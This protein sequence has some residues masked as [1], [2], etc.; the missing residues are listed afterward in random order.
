MLSV[1]VLAFS[2]VVLCAPSAA[3]I[4]AAAAGDCSLVGQLDG[5]R[6]AAELGGHQLAGF[7]LVNDVRWTER[8]Y[9]GGVTEFRNDRGEPTHGRWRV[10]GDR[11]CFSYGTMTAWTCK[12]VHRVA[13]ACNA[14][15]LALVDEAGRIASGI[16]AATP[17]AHG[18]VDDAGPASPDALGAAMARERSWSLPVRRGLQNALVWTGDYNGVVDGEFGPRTRAAIRSFQRGLGAHATGYL[19]EGEIA[20]LEAAR[21]AAVGAAGFRVVEDHETGIRVGLPEAMLRRSGRDDFFV[22]YRS[23]PDRP[24]ARLLL[25]SWAAGRDEL[26]MLF[27]AVLSD[28]AL[29][30]DPYA[31]RRDEWFVVSGTKGGVTAYSHARFEDG[32]L[33]GFFLQWPSSDSAIFG[34]I[35]TAMYNSFDALPGI[36]LAPS[37]VEAPGGNETPYATRNGDHAP[38]LP[39]PPAPEAELVGTGSGFV[40]DGSGKVLTNAHVVEGCSAVEVGEGVPA[41]LTGID[42]AADL[43]LLQARGGQWPAVAGFSARPARLNSDVTVAG[44]PLHDLLGSLNVTRGAVSASSGPANDASVFQITAAVQPGNSGGP[45]LDEQGAVVGVVQSKLNAVRVAAATGDIPQNISFAIRGEIAKLFLMRHRVELR[46]MEAR[47][48]LGPADLADEAQAFTVLVR[49]LSD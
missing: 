17:L 6:I 28:G 46:V 38:T 20:R 41:V 2:L 15:R 18:G 24:A 5:A 49:C 47:E 30:T 34:P 37:I 12:T 45:V 13:P 35:A 22:E 19:T 40:V 23:R 39:E 10:T 3:S 11:L 9:P 43:A 26:G 27:D 14:F 1:R 8:L 25:L 36:V 42:T 44:Y 33:K 48:P 7:S 29:G 16:F 4:H 32:A 21:I 31:V